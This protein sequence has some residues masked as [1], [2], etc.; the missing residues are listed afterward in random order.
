[1]LVVLRVRNCSQEAEEVTAVPPAKTLKK[2]ELIISDGVNLKLERL[3][4]CRR[5]SPHVISFWYIL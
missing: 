4:S 5:V 3:V 2:I 1:M